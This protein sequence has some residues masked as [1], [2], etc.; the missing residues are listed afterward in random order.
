MG[1]AQLARF[2]M[3]DESDLARAYGLAMEGWRAF[4]DTI[5]GKICLSI[6]KGIAAP[7]YSLTAMALDGPQKRSVRVTHKNLPTLYFRA[8]AWDLLQQLESSH[9]YQL[10]WNDDKVRAILLSGKPVA[11]WEV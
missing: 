5:G 6:Y 1:Q 4:P 10:L 11:Q 7:D 8:Y 2:V 9:D 3:S